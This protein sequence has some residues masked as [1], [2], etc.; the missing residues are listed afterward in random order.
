MKPRC[1]A[2]RPPSA[3]GT[4]QNSGTHV[5]IGINA[6]YLIPGGVGGTEVYLRRLIGAL[7][8]LGTEHDFIVFAN[9]ETGRLGRHCVELPIRA[10]SRPARILYEQF[11][12]PA[13]LRRERIDVLFNPGFTAPLAAGVPQVTVFHDLQHKRHPEYF[14][15]F[16]LPFWEFF[17]WAS[18]KRSQKLIAVSEATRDDLQK[19]YGA[20]AAVVHHGVEEQFFQL[21]GQRE[22]GGYLLCASTTHPHKNHD[23]LLRVFAQLRRE[24]PEIRLVLTGV[25]GF[26]TDRVETLVKELD[27]SESVELKGWV[28]R[29]ELYELFRRARGFVY[30]SLFEGFGMPVL[31]AMAAG[32]PVACS[33]IEPLRSIAAGRALLF[34]PESDPEMLAALRRLAGGQAPRGGPERA[35]QFTW[36]RAAEQTLQVILSAG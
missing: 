20:G 21:A 16:D 3:P 34:S 23:R 11:S 17:L 10:S 6:L 36:R 31:E 30:P 9:R 28:P 1:R 15:W 8:D 7:E 29:E 13:A 33:D 27:L 24:Q 2:N 22:D 25:R 12:L 5:R 18:V 4:P 26:V 35:A 19:Y 14:R 32:L